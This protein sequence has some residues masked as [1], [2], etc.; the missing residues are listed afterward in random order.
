MSEW[1]TLKEIYEE[2]GKFPFSADISGSVYNPYI[3]HAIAKKG[4]FLGE[5]CKGDGIAWLP[6]T[7]AKLIPPEK[8][9]KKVYEWLVQSKS[10]NTI[11][12]QPYI[13]I[14][15]EDMVKVQYPDAKLTKLREFEI[16]VEE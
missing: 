3:F 10:R 11:F 13:I 2:V 6:L 14:G 12:N 5:D 15:D 7:Q 4:H 9:K 1:K 16:E 8:P